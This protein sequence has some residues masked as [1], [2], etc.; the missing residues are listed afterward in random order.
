MPLL[1]LTAE[2]AQANLRKGP[3]VRWPDGRR[4]TRRLHGLATVEFD[5]SFKLKPGEAVFTIGS[6]F[7]RNIERRLATA[8]FEV[9][10]S[11]VVIPEAER[12]STLGDNELL[13]KYGPHTMINELRWAFDPGSPFPE[14]G[15]LQ[16]GE[17]AWHD[18]HLTASVAPMSLERVQERRAMVQA[19]YRQ[20]P[21]C[22][23]VVITL[24]LAE[25]WFDL[26]TGLYLNRAPPTE[27]LKREPKRF[28]LDLLSYSE[29]AE[30]LETLHGLL[31]AHGK[32]GLRVLI[33]VSPVPFRVTFTGQDAITAN[34]YSKSV[35]RAVVEAYVRGHPEVDY[36]PSYEIV[37]HTARTLAYYNDERHISPKVVESIVDRM[38]AAYGGSALAADVEAAQAAED[39][40]AAPSDA[41]RAADDLREELKSGRTRP[42]LR[43]FAFLDTPERLAK[44]GLDAFWFR[45]QYGRVLL[46]DDQ[47]L[48]AEVQIAKALAIDPESA[49][50]HFASGLAS[51]GLQRSLQAEAAFRRAVELDP[52]NAYYQARL[53]HEMIRNHRS[54]E[55]ESVALRGL[56]ASPD[57]E[58]LK[59]VLS[60]AR[61]DEALALLKMERVSTSGWRRFKALLGRWARA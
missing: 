54:Q 14:A 38:V 23:V 34:S 41:A 46:K 33:T 4:D 22:R 36:F 1:S 21:R 9:P 20:L 58:R 60:A 42:T 7:A 25:T 52:D 50:A 10:A 11:A 53:A 48:E 17:N 56:A 44:A 5:P 59:K 19:F 61:R 12:G 40:A 27:S 45:Y 51:A 37:T 2:Q 13:N 3:R 24:G 28:R 55:A 18:P 47:P 16:V 57:D 8:G 6:C 31:K 49:N 35:L 30:A 32:R 15:Y 39:G 26:K 29:L 43:L